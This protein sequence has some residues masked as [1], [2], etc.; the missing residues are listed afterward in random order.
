ML[1]WL[2][3]WQ[4]RL[5]RRIDLDILWPECKANAPDITLAK[6]AFAMHAFHDRAWLVLGEDEIR[7]QIDELK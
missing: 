6:V 3:S 2:F 5:R 7:R 4:H 1:D